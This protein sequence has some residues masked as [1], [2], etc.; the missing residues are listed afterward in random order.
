MHAGGVPELRLTVCSESQCRHASVRATC[1]KHST[2]LCR[3]GCTTAMSE[4]WSCNTSNCMCRDSASRPSL[5]VISWK[6]SLNAPYFALPP[7]L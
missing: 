2:T 4:G 6:A 3:R 1:R 5:A 7:I